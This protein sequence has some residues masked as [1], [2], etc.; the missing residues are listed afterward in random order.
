MRAFFAVADHVSHGP[1]E[2]VGD[3]TLDGRAVIFRQTGQRNA[4]EVKPGLVGGELL[5]LL[6]Q[7]CGVYSQTSSSETTLPS[8]SYL[9]M[10]FFFG[11]L[12][13]EEYCCEYCCGCWEYC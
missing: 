8:A 10:I 11:W 4:D 1:G 7:N 12:L 5:Y 13:L 2:A 3:P 9:R 6:G